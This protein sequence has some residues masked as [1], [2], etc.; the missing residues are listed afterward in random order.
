M[1]FVALDFETANPSLDS[2]C[3]IGVVVFDDSR[4]VDTWLTLVDPEDYFDGMNISIH[5][6]QPAH[7][8]GA[9]KFPDV[10]ERLHRLLAGKTV[11]HHTAFDK[12]ALARAI[13]KYRLADVACE[14]LDTA[15][16]ARR[17]WQEFAQSGYGLASVAERLGIT[18]AHHAAH[19]DARAAGE[20][21]IHA[22][23]QTGLTIADWH[24]RVR[25]PVTARHSGL[26]ATSCA[27]DGDPDGLL[28]GEVVVFTGALALPRHQ[29]ADLAAKAGC[30]VAENVTA[31]TTML[32][33]GDQDSRKLAGYEKSSKHRKSELLIAKGH[34][35]R[36]VTEDDFQQLVNSESGAAVS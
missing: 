30:S 14:W 24:A 27:R 36:I 12:V 21:L 23:R 22:S 3:Q 7:V 15:R 29:M 9:P 17:A 20:I 1:Q 6:I 31:K 18:F 19:E 28:F 34:S 16:V 11:A 13:S 35:I 32:V 5:G 2:I 26:G 8:V 25:R 33:V 4:P 10:F